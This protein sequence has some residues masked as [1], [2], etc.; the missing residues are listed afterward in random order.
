M[1]LLLGFILFAVLPDT[2]L[3]I[4]SYQLSLTQI[5]AF[6]VMRKA[7]PNI[8]EHRH[9][10]IDIS[11]PNDDYDNSLIFSIATGTVISK[12]DD[13]PYAQLIISHYDEKKVYWTVYEHISGIMVGLGD[14]VD[15]KRPIARF[16]N[17]DELNQYGWQF[18][19][20]H[21]EVLK[22]EPMK[23]KPSVKHPERRY[24]SYTLQAFSEQQLFK[25][26]YDPLYFLGL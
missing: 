19:H 14:Q 25:Y 7:R 9:S 17:R 5:G 3:P 21:F 1:K 8:P 2:R 4:N 26:F 16:F 11:R 23:I 20:F 22:V 24:N 13:G 6:G 18:D 12:R 10:G 15:P